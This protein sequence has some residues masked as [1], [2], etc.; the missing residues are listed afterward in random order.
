MSENLCQPSTSAEKA[1][2]APLVLHQNWRNEGNETIKPRGQ[3]AVPSLKI[4]TRP[5]LV[6]FKMKQ[7][8]ESKAPGQKWG[9][10]CCFPIGAPG[11]HDWTCP[12]RR[13]PGV[14]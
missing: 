8:C 13:R 9:L 6:L 11:V 12:R 1:T 2:G 10:S 14:R 7:R 5:Y 3:P 4:G